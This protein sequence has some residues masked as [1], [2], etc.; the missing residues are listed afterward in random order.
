MPDGDR[1]VHGAEEVHDLHVAPVGEDGLLVRAPAARA[2]AVVDRQDD[3]AVGGEE[4]AVEAEGVL[5]LSVRPAVD[6]EE[7]RVFLSGR[8]RGRLD[9]QVR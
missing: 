3:V 6:V 2:A 4:L 7:G 1:L 8:K 5:V 9:H